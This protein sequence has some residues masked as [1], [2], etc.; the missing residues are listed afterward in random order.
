MQVLWT[1]H[2]E[3]RQF[4]WQQ[5]LGITCED[6]EEVV[7]YP[8]QIIYDDEIIA[9]SFYGKGLLRVVLIEI[10]DTR[11]ILTLYWTNQ[12]ARYWQEER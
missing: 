8:Q 9:Q 7:Q 11:R 2:T 5:R 10:G 6:V 3:E 12:V 4:Q 1:K